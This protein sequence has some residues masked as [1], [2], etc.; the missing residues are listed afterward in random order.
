MEDPAHVTGPSGNPGPSPDVAESGDGRL[1]PD[2]ETLETLPLD[3]AMRL[4]ANEVRKAAR[5]VLRSLLGETADRLKRLRESPV[6]DSVDG[7]LDFVKK[8][9]VQGALIAIFV[10]FLLGRSMRK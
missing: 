2:E 4:A 3:E 6:V 1:G 5:L 7:V 9:P 10:G 8:T